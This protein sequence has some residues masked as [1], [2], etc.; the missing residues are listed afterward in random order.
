MGALA[1]K[2]AN[3][4]ENI[5]S[6]NHEVATLIVVGVAIII[7]IYIY[8]IKKW[9]IELINLLKFKMLFMIKE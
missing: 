5:F 4:L 2:I 9:L 6:I 8:F 1:D 7:L 3:F